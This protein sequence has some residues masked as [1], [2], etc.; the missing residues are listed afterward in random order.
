MT[1]KARSSIFSVNLILIHIFDQLIFI[2]LIKKNRFFA[3]LF[4]GNFGRQ[5]KIGNLRKSNLFDKEK[6]SYRKLN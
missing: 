3:L 1:V 2:E 5:K 6:L 4:Q